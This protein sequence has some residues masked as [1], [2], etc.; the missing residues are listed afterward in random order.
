MYLVMILHILIKSD[1]I[2]GW[3]GYRDYCVFYGEIK[4]IKIDGKWHKVVKFEKTIFGL[5]I[6][7]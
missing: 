2:C 4:K 3:D 7:V 1:K 5:E 6:Y